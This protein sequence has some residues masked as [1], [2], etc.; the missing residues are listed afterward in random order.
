MEV[1]HVVRPLRPAQCHASLFD[2]LEGNNV[3]LQIPGLSIP[4]TD[5]QII[6]GGGGGGG[7][8][9]GGGGRSL[10]AI[11]SSSCLSVPQATRP[12]KSY[13]DSIF[14]RPQRTVGNESKAQSAFRPSQ[15]SDSSSLMLPPFLQDPAQPQQ[16]QQQQQQ[17][18]SHQQQQQQQQQEIPAPPPL[19]STTQRQLDEFEEVIARMETMSGGGGGGGGGG[20]DSPAVCQGVHT[21]LPPP[22]YPG[23]HQDVSPQR[24][25]RNSE[26]QR[27]SPYHEQSYYGSKSSQDYN[28]QQHR[29]D[30]HFQQHYGHHHHQQQQQQQHQQLDPFQQQQQPQ[31]QQPLPSAFSNNNQYDSQKVNTSF[32]TDVGVT[33]METDGFLAPGMENTHHHQQ[34]NHHHHHHHHHHQQQQQ[35]HQHQQQHHQHHHQQQQQLANHYHQQVSPQLS[36]QVSP[37]VSPFTSPYTSP[38]TSPSAT[39]AA[40]PPGTSQ[41]STP[42]S[43][44]PSR[45]SSADPAP[46]SSTPLTQPTSTPTPSATPTPQV[47]IEVT[48]PWEAGG[49]GGGGS[50]GGG[51]GGGRERNVEGRVVGLPPPGPPSNVKT[52]PTTSRTQLKQQLMRQQL[53]QQ[54]EARERDARMQQQNQMQQQQHQQHQQLQQHQQRMSQQPNGA[55]TIP[56]SVP[57]DVPPQVLQVQTRLENPTYYHV[58]QSQR[59]QVRQFITSGGTPQSTPPSGPSTSKA[60][61][62]A[63]AWPH[64]D[65]GASSKTLK[66]GIA[67]PSLTSSS[68]GGEGAVLAGARNGGVS[69]GGGG[70]GGGVVG[71]RIVGRGPCSPESPAASSSWNSTST[72]VPSTA[73]PS[74]VSSVISSSAASLSDASEVEDVID[75]ILNL[76]EGLEASDNLKNYDQIN[77][78]AP[79][80]LN[81]VPAICDLLGLNGCIGVETSNS[82]PPDVPQVKS[83]TTPISDQQMVAYMKDRQKKDNHNMIE[84]RRRFNINDRIKELATLLP[85]SNEP[86]FELVR[87]LRHNKGQILKASVDYIRRLKIDIEYNKEVEAKRRALEQQNRQLLIRIQE[88]E[89][90][91]RDNGIKV[92]EANIDQSLLLSTLI[93]SEVVNNNTGGQND[94]KKVRCNYSL[95]GS[96]LDELLEDFTSGG[97]NL[98]LMDDDGPA[99]T[100]DPVFSSPQVSSPNSSHHSFEDALTPD[101]MDIVA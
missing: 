37:H 45:R 25:S 19:D 63:P 54:Q 70:G 4:G 82:C 58:I 83:E 69:G 71:P 53:Q 32:Q 27:Y 89:S 73:P 76:E 93:K 81:S 88:L 100:S 31:H 95:P 38:H 14:L 6:G 55:I 5:L 84:R 49:G 64:S 28:S 62:A 67:S 86:Y 78:M 97:F 87:D 11:T 91:L 21:Y 35:Q 79:S 68:V 24:Y 77:S 16:Q 52:M 30:L 36:P 12:C 42:S 2:Q 20:N 47:K 72:P 74:A 13:D 41:P 3:G 29:H 17:L 96:L 22:A 92:E 57:P 9:V 59:R 75:E 43:R 7:G 10:D 61:T 85:K 94:M 44:P 48:G 98:D 80:Q 50:G 8:G 26:S 90:K 39:V 23:H 66:S 15:Q 34:Q 40:T 60:V 18:H 51:G 33:N 1:P 46:T 56:A 101:S 99:F 65:P